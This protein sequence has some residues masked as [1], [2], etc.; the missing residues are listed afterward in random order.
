MFVS[1][2]IDPQYPQ[3]LVVDLCPMLC[4]KLLAIVVQSQSQG[5]VPRVK[6]NERHM[7]S[8][9]DHAGDTAAGTSRLH[10]AGR[11]Q[12]HRCAAL[13]IGTLFRYRYK[14]HGI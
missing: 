11:T 6:G 12:G 13:W 3:G 9:S 8:D 4:T 2:Y 1:A 14:L 7:Y 5:M 10:T